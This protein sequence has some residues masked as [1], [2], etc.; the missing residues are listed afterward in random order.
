MAGRGARAAAVAPGRIPRQRIVRDGPYLAAAFRQG[1]AEAG[2]HE[3]RN[4]ALAY[5]WQEG[6]YERVQTYLAEL[7]SSRPAVLVVGGIVASKAA[8]ALGIEVP[9]MLLS[10]ADEVIE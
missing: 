3:S 7:L 2:Y 8:K 9:P 1:L 5:R 4:V 6:Q 10:R